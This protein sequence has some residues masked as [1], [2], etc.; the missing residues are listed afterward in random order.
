MSLLT[1]QAKPPR[2]ATPRH[3]TPCHATFFLESSH[4]WYNV[5]YS[6]SFLLHVVRYKKSPVLHLIY[7]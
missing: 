2:L 7:I 3:A 4:F 6:P 5:R 1:K